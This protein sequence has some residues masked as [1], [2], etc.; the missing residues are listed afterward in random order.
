MI[1]GMQL[2]RAASM[3]QDDGDTDA[4]LEPRDAAEKFMKREIPHRYADL[5]AAA[6]RNYSIF[7]PGSGATSEKP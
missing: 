6:N 3:S 4:F 5:T 7:R 2:G 1:G